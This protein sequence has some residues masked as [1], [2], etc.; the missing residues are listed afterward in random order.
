MSEIVNKKTEK[1]TRNDLYIIFLFL[2]QFY[3]FSSLNSLLGYYL[4]RLFAVQNYLVQFSGLL[5]GTALFLVITNVIGLY[6]S[7][8]EGVEKTQDYLVGVM[9]RTVLILILYL[10][11]QIL[12]AQT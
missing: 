3:L 12:F 5:L 2:I 11:V 1:I 10:V 8:K 6:L 7:Y 4:G 9:Q